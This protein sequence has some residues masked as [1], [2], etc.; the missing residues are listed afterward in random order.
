MGKFYF[1]HNDKWYWSYILVSMISSMLNHTGESVLK[2]VQEQK[3]DFWRGI[4]SLTQFA[5]NRK[6]QMNAEQ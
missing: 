3:C 2:A 6:S 1:F 4:K 5:L